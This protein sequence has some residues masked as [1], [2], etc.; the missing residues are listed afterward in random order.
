LWKFFIDILID[1]YSLVVDK[2]D[3]N[4][5]FTCEF[6][7]GHDEGDA[8]FPTPNTSSSRLGCLVFQK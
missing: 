7:P 4:E 2:D 8:F 3:E 1:L 6:Y 5:N